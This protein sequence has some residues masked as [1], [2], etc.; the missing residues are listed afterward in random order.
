MSKRDVED[1][2]VVEID[3]LDFGDWERNMKT[4]EVPVAGLAALVRQT[5]AVPVVAKRPGPTQHTVAGVAPPVTARPSMLP[6]TPL[7]LRAPAPDPA[8]VETPAADV[9][10]RSPV[11]RTLLLAGGA[12]AVA[13]T[14]VVIVLARGSKSAPAP[15]QAPTH[16]PTTAPDPVAQ[17][18]PAAPAKAAAQSGPAAAPVATKPA[19][20]TATP[21]PPA[22]APARA[23]ATPAAAPARVRATA[24]KEPAPRPKAVRRGRPVKKAVAVRAAPP[25]AAAPPADPDAVEQGRAAYNAGNE[26]LF[27][28]DFDAAIKAYQQVLELSPLFAFGQ[29]GLGLAYAQKGDNAAAIKALREYLRLAPRAKDVSLIKKRIRSLQAAKR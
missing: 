9:A 1:M 21:P 17:T 2:E 7:P 5:A 25:P 8:P 12:I 28:G 4:S 18:A 11:P 3:A 26:A 20:R 16:A 10:L 27:A 24:A 19:S 14:I 23:K 6:A 15:A 22:P 13:I 29:R